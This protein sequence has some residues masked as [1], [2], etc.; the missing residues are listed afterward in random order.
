MRLIRFLSIGILYAIP[1][2]LASIC[3]RIFLGYDS[4][5]FYLDIAN[6]MNQVSYAPIL[7]G[8]SGFLL[9]SISFFSCCGHWFIGK[10]SK[11]FQLKSANGMVA[12][13]LKTIESFI[14]RL[15]KD[16]AE[17]KEIHPKINVNKNSI[18]LELMLKLWAGTNVPEASEQ[19][20]QDFKYQIQNVLGIENVGLINIEI[21][22]IAGKKDAPFVK[23][24]E[25][26]KP[27]FNSRILEGN[28]V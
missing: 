24:K 16:Y 10:K 14:L 7:L 9:L 25:I 18:S 13:P 12:L 17:V 21:L 28:E 19:I 4:T 6:K 15:A 3:L 26:I 2:V 23:P 27:S 5:Q 8:I 1:L 11:I 20:Q 22:E